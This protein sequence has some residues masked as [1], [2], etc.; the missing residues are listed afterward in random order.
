MDTILKTAPAS[1]PSGWR[2][3]RS[4]WFRRAILGVVT[5]LMTWQRRIED[6]EIL[7]SMTDASLKDIGISRAEIEREAEKPFWRA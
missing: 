2:T 6:R 5:P 7:R 4:H 1:L 3:P